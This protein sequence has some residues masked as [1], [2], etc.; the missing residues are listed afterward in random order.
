M[1][2]APLDPSDLSL[3]I[4]SAYGRTQNQ[5]HIH[6]D[7]IAPAVRAALLAH[8]ADIADHWSAFPEKLAGHGY[9][10]MRVRSLDRPGANPFRLVADGIP[11]ARTDMAHETLLVTGAVSAKRGLGFYLLETRADL[12]TGNRGSAEE[13][14]DHDCTLAR[15]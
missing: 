12:A 15:K 4:N 14:Q 2:G 3:A 11:G 13:L 7:C 10:I 5:F 1:A 6:I 9:R 8:A